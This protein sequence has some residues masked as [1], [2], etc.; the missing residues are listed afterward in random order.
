MDHA[1]LT[2]LESMNQAM[3]YNRWT[4]GKF[5]RYVRGDILEVGCGIGNFTPS[6]SQYGRVWAFDVDEAAASATNKRVKRGASVGLGDIENGTYFFGNKRFST[7]V[8]L[9]VLEHIKN[10]SQALGNMRRLL[11]PGGSLI[12]LVP[13]HASLFGTIDSSIGHFRRYKPKALISE[14][15]RQGFSILSQRKL[16]LFGAIGWFITGKLLKRTSVNNSYIR[17]FNLFSPLLL[18]LEDIVAPP[19]GTSLLLIA[20]LPARQAR[21]RERTRQSE[22]S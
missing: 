5:A 14:V 22:A 7:I 11:V 6:L 8:C 4:L 13:I 21:R 12:L 1:S 17:L 19:F 10:D 9:N 16:T 15:K 18:P 20:R 3:W 2:T